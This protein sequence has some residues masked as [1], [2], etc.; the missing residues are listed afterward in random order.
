[1]K[2]CFRNVRARL[3]V[4][5]LIALIAASCAGK[6]TRPSD[7]QL[8][9]L[10]LKFNLVQKKFDNGL[11]VLIVEDHTVPV[12]SYQ[13]WVNVGSVDEE[14]GT[15]GIA[16]LFEHL[17]FKGSAKYGPRAFFQE[18]EAKGANVNAYT[19]RDYTVFHESFVPDLLPKVIDLESDRLASLRLSDE[20]LFTERQVVFEER[21]LRT[22]SSPE[23]RVQEALWGLAYRAHP[24][25]W[26]VIGY[27]EDLNRITIEDLTNFFGKYYQPGNVTLVIVGDVDTKKTLELLD[28]AYAWIPGR[29]RPARSIGKEPEQ[30]EERRIVIKDRVAAEKVAMG[31]VVTRAED[32]DTYALDVLAN[33]LFA[34]NGSRATQRIVEK[35]DLALGIS[36]VAYTPLYPGLFMI[37]ATLKGKHT[38]S[39]LEAE[40]DQVLAE[41]QENGVTD[42]EISTAV[43]QLTVQT[44]DSVRTAHGLGTLIGTVMVIFGDPNRYQSDLAKYLNV[45][46]D[47]VRRVAKKYLTKKRRNVVTLVPGQGEAE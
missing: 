9:K 45:T 23:G 20:V 32:D 26:P 39:E 28:V 40:L 19:T 36:G 47:D 27:S 35:K 31:Y 34:G 44:V 42:E 4:A 12:V 5:G 3:A 30:T 24:Y 11:N 2:L 41:V 6:S 21:R 15:T 10:G 22:E 14:F 8:A 46:K 17:M 18:L 13:T 25:R 38:A 29:P 37:N 1:M 7:E 16:H 43:R 33:I